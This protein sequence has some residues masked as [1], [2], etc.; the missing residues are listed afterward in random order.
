M[1]YSLHFRSVMEQNSLSYTNSGI[2]KQIIISPNGHVQESH[3][4][5][6]L[7]VSGKK[8]CSHCENELGK[9]SCFSR[10][11]EAIIINL[12]F[13]FNCARKFR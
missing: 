4:D 7:S 11:R 6:I 13:I 12:N 9:L 2:E 10:D 8:K 1:Y 3:Q 5:K